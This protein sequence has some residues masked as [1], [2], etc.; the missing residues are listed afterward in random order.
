MLTVYKVYKR[1]LIDGRVER[2]LSKGSLD[3]RSLI[4]MKEEMTKLMED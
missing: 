1:W 4:E 2:K 3:D